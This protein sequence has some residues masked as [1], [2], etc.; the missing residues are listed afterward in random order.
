MVRI[1]VVPLPVGWAVHTS[2]IDNPSV[3]LSGARAEQMARR[4]AQAALG[5]GFTVVLEITTRDGWVVFG[6]SRLA[7]SRMS[8]EGVHT[9]ATAADPITDGALVQHSRGAE[10]RP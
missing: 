3:F 8:N 10:A 6:G 9:L 1:S 7:E 2:L 4:L 5:L